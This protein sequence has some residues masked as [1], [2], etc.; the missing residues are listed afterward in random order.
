MNWL[1][2]I[3]NILKNI[4]GL[5]N[6]TP[7]REVKRRQAAKSDVLE[8][9]YNQDELNQMYKFIKKHAKLLRKARGEKT[10]WFKKKE[11]LIKAHETIP[12]VY[13][14]LIKELEGKK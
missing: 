10:S 7:D 8:I 5:I 4:T 13:N 1:A 2:P 9:E 11:P 6:K 14:R 3:L 12:E